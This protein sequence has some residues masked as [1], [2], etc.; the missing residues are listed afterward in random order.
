[1]ASPVDHAL[2]SSVALPD[3]TSPAKTGTAEAK[4]LPA[5]RITHSDSKVIGAKLPD[6][7]SLQFVS[8]ALPKADAPVVVLFWAKYAKGD[9]R[10]MV[11]FSYLM[12]ALPGLQICGVSVDAEIDD[13]HSMLKKHGTP[14]PTQSIDELIFDF[15]MAFDDKR[16]VKD[17]FAKIGHPSPAP[18]FAY[19]FDKAGVCVWAETFTSAWALKQG[20][21]AEQCALILAGEPL[22]DNGP[23]PA[24]ED[25]ED[26]GEACTTDVGDLTIGGDY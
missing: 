9:Y 19:L 12:R 10:T 23:K 18:G 1:M 24:A 17:Q 22:M 5:D 25:D 2:L 26:E 7:S 3:L 6:L 15:P 21:F 8:G 20:Q 13:C 4:A 11:H 16:I 14:M